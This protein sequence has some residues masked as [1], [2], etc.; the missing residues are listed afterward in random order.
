MNI[1]YRLSTPFLTVHRSNP[2]QTQIIQT[3]MYTTML[4]I[5]IY[6][7]LGMYC[8]VREDTVPYNPAYT[9]YLR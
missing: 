8:Y 7:Q 1:I 6:P 4:Y 9:G 2:V 3:V 5:Y